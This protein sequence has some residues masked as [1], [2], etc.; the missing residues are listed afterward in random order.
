MAKPAFLRSPG[1]SAPIKQWEPAG[2]GAGQLQHWHAA[3]LQTYTNQRWTQNPL[4]SPR[5]SSRL[6]TRARLSLLIHLGVLWMDWELPYDLSGLQ[7]LLLAAQSALDSFHNVKE[8]KASIRVE[9]HRWEILLGKDV[10]QAGRPRRTLQTLVFQGLIDWNYTL[11]SGSWKLQQIS[12]K[13]YNK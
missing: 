11:Y 1:L 9:L 4:H 5:H 7:L 3:C 8:T 6:I 13:Y 12:Q 10:L 2:P